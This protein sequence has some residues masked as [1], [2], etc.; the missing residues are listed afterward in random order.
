MDSSFNLNLDEYNLNDIMDL[1]GLDH[2]FSE[3]ELRKAKKVIMKVHPDKS[4]LD[5]KF[6]IFFSKAY[7]I[8]CYIY[9]FRE[10]HGN[11]GCVQ[12]DGSTYKDDAEEAKF[13]K[14]I[15]SNDFNKKFNELF[16]ANM[17]RS[18]F[19]SGGYG[20]WYKNNDKEIKDKNDKITITSVSQMSD[21]FHKE[22]IRTKS[23]IEYKGVEQINTIGSTGGTDLAMNRP[24]NYSSELFS[25]LPYEDLRK[26]HEENVVPVLESDI[27]RSY[28]SFEQLQF[29]RDVNE[30]SFVP[31]DGEELKSHLDE[32]KYS[33]SIAT[34]ERAFA[35]AKQAEEATKA[36]KNFAKN[37]QFLTF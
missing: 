10:K 7:N 17:V 2:G 37:F 26:A 34:S 4:K 29:Q 13:A 3:T 32:K 28:N 20:D 16:E 15:T 24:E 8:L 23:L 27:N 1:F 12:Y 18:D 5:E 31:L 21:A 30:R 35:L 6:F 19:E 22:R 25:K 11:D 36:K 9:K 14:F 33:E